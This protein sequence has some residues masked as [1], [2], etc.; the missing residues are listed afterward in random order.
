[1]LNALYLASKPRWVNHLIGLQKNYII[2]MAMGM[3]AVLFAVGHKLISSA[4]G[5]TQVTGY[6]GLIILVLIA[7]FPSLF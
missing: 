5:L 1:M 6:T 3:G 7:V 2:H 4:H